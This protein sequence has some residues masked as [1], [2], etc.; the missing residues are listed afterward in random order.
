MNSCD[1]VTNDV[2][3]ILDKFSTLKDNIRVLELGKKEPS[4]LKYQKSEAYGQDGFTKVSEDAYA[5]FERTSRL[6][7]NSKD[8]YNRF[9]NE[10]YVGKEI[11]VM[12]SDDNNKYRYGLISKIEDDII[13]G[14]N[15]EITITIDLQ[16]FK[17]RNSNDIIIENKETIIN[18]GNVYTF[19]RIKVFGSGKGKIYINNQTMEL[20]VDEYLIIDCKEID[21]FDKNGLRANSRRLS[22]N[23][24]RIN[25]GENIINFDGNINKLELYIGWRWR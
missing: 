5:G 11:K 18:P 21:I 9:M 14:D 10:F 12:Y 8:S 1:Y 22:G 20:D 25:P 6:L 15:R 19:P 7:I 3:I 2:F 24:F 17:Y 4:S 23:F 13:V 16:P